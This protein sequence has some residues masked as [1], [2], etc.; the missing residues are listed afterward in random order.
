M[1]ESKGAKFILVRFSFFLKRMYRPTAY[2]S[3]STCSMNSIA[4][5]KQLF[6][7][8]RYPSALRYFDDTVPL[9]LNESLRPADLN[10]IVCKIVVRGVITNISKLDRIR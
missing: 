3:I 7:G 1:Y 5:S 4:K 2:S 9:V 10:S 6:D 8:P